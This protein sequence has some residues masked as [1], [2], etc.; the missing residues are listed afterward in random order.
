MYVCIVHVDMYVYVYMYVCVYVCI[1]TYIRANVCVHMYSCRRIWFICTVPISRLHA[2]ISQ[3][4]LNTC[5]R[6][7]GGIGSGVSFSLFMVSA[8]F[9]RGRLCF[10]RGRDRGFVLYYFSIFAGVSVVGGC[11]LVY[12]RTHKQTTWVLDVSP[13]VGLG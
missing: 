9:W 10:R 5:M 8:C 12:A 7:C 11:V 13:G 4:F 3:V 2:R 1:Y 6:V